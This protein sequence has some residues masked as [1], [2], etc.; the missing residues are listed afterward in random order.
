MKEGKCLLVGFDRQLHNR[1][2]QLCP[3]TWLDRAETVEEALSFLSEMVYE[4]LILDSHAAK[5]LEF[6]RHLNG[7]TKLDKMKRAVCLDREYNNPEVIHAVLKLKVSRVFYHPIEPKEIA[8]E[9]ATTTR[10]TAPSISLVPMESKKSRTIGPLVRTFKEVTRSRLLRMLIDAPTAS[11]DPT[12]RRELQREAH[13]LKGSMG[14]FGFPRGSELAAKLESHLRSGNCEPTLITQHCREI[15]TLLDQE[16]E[17]LV[18]QN[19]GEPVVLIFTSDEDLMVDL[20][21][22]ASI[23]NIRTLVLN[24]PEDV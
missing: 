19:S 23:E 3:E 15:L 16:G 12:A 5:S 10:L 6:L 20:T 1:L 18:T 7:I 21:S 22:A 8:R 2:T 9:L 4:Q 24:N 14:S 17:A 11:D 13:K